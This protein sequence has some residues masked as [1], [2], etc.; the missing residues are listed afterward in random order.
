MFHN[1]L[2]LSRIYIGYIYRFNK[3]FSSCGRSG[4]CPFFLVSAAF[5]PFGP[6]ILLKISDRHV[7]EKSIY[8]PKGGAVCGKYGKGKWKLETFSLTSRSVRVASVLCNCYSAHCASVLCKCCSAT[9]TLW[10]STVTNRKESE[11]VSLLWD[12]PGWWRWWLWWKWGS[13]RSRQCH[14]QWMLQQF[15]KV[16]CLVNFNFCISHFD[17]HCVP[18]IC[19]FNSNHSLVDICSGPWSLYAV[20]QI[21]GFILPMHCNVSL[22]IQSP[23]FVSSSTIKLK[24]APLFNNNFSQKWAGTSTTN[25]PVFL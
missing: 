2:F 7:F 16:T 17:L 14:C 12:L 20:I 3:V 9:A 22:L 10:T 4:S 23:R 25:S 15:R 6:W 19:F 21:A 13:C 1:F 18:F 8:W 5:P 11:E 24:I